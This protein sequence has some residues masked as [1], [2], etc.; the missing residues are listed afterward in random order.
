MNHI[1]QLALAG[2]HDTPSI[3]I[4]GKLHES[5]AMAKPYQ[6]LREKLSNQTRHNLNY[7]QFLYWYRK[8]TEQTSVSDI[9]DFVPVDIKSP[10]ATTGNL[11]VLEFPNG[12][13]LVINSPVLL[14]QIP[15]FMDL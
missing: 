2:C 15:G 9:P 11:G 8:L 14:A 3:N 4:G 7:S 13:K 5:A 6:G 12:V 10:T 1:I